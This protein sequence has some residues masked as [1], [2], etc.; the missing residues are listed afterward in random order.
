MSV[1]TAGLYVITRLQ[2]PRR[3]STQTPKH[4]CLVSQARMSGFSRQPLVQT[5]HVLSFPSS[6]HP[7]VRYTRQGTSQHINFVIESI[8]EQYTSKPCIRL[9]RLSGLPVAKLP[10]KSCG[11]GG[12]LCLAGQA[13]S[14]PASLI[15]RRTTPPFLS[16]TSSNA[17][18][19]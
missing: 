17:R 8:R 6:W 7:S 12:G 5:P 2:L 1:D 3:L 10:A 13:A 4:G 11:G 15:F 18:T 14:T 16:T 9:L 19:R